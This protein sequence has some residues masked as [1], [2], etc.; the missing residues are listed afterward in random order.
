MAVE[1]N[2]RPSSIRKARLGDHGVGEVECR[3]TKNDPLTDKG[4]GQLRRA[5]RIALRKVQTQSHPCG[6]CRHEFSLRRDTK[7]SA[8]SADAHTQTRCAS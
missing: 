1:G 4:F 8:R 3:D 7:E 5:L 2:Q 6:A